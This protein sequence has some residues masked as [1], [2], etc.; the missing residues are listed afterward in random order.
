[1]SNSENHLS[2]EQLTLLRLEL[3][4][5]F[6][7]LGRSMKASRRAARPVT[8]DQTSVGRLSR[9]DAIQNQSLSQGIQAREQVKAALLTSA[10]ERMDRGTYGV[11][12]G[13]GEAIR[14][15]RLELFPETPTCSRCAS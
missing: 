12:T 3:E 10:L 9:I 8:L 4:R 1:M 5:A 6:E 7:K 11:C 2:R 15:E 13:C 14:F